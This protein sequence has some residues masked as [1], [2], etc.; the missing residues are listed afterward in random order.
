MYSVVCKRAGYSTSPS[1]SLAGTS[2]G[3]SIGH[4]EG[5]GSLPGE[6]LP[7]SSLT[8]A[9]ASASP[10]AWPQSP[11][12]ALAMPA[13][14]LSSPL[15][16]GGTE[17]LAPPPPWSPV[18]SASAPLPGVRASGDD[19]SPTDSSSLLASST[20]SSSMPRDMA[21][22]FTLAVNLVMGMSPAPSSSPHGSPCAVAP[23]PR[24][25]MALLSPPAPKPEAWAL[26]GAA[27]ASSSS[28]SPSPPSSS[29][30][31]LSADE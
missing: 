29:S 8:A 17:L 9:A 15:P 16:A 26:P 18:A 21:D 22:V 13:L 23:N 24:P 7:L 4:D 1:A 5:G 11:P 3:T 10:L 25:D 30:S 12:L 27:P 28:S 20:S 2:L 14:A 6:A 31:S 19:A